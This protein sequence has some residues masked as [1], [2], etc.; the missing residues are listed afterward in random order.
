MFPILNE[1]MVASGPGNLLF[2]WP[3][4]CDAFKRLRK[5]IRRGTYEKVTVKP[6]PKPAGGVKVK[7]PGPVG[8][9]L[10]T[11]AMVCVPEVVKLPPVVN[12]TPLTILV[13]MTYVPVVLTVT[14]KT[15]V[16]LACKLVAVL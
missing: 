15:M 12:W 8:M 13:L 4:T 2:G 5:A 6:H 1:E 7:V 3:T 16:L 9:P 10:P 14:S 11:S